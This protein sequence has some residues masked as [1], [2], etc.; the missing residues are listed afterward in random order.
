MSSVKSQEDYSNI[1]SGSTGSSFAHSHPCDASPSVLCVP[2]PRYRFLLYFLK[3]HI[4]ARLLPWVL[5][6]SSCHPPLFWTAQGPSNKNLTPEHG[7]LG[8][9]WLWNRTLT[10]TWSSSSFLWTTC[11]IISSLPAFENPSH[12]CCLTNICLSHLP[13]LP[14]LSSHSQSLQLVHLPLCVCPVLTFGFFVSF[15]FLLSV[16]HHA[17]MRRDCVLYYQGK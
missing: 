12:N 7:I 8:L 16:L 5:V 10:S 13:A 14:Y 17:A 6:G 4:V 9:S 11:L 2:V 15:K 3:I 1:K